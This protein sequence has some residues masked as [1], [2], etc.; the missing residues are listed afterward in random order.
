MGGWGALAIVA[1][2]ADAGVAFAQSQT[3]AGDLKGVVVDGS[4]A[5]VAGAS[6]SVVNHVTGYRR[7]ATTGPDGHYAIHALPIGL[8]RLEARLPGFETIDVP[9]VTLSL[10]APTVVDLVLQV[11]GVSYDLVVTPAR[12]LNDAAE[13]GEGLVIDRAEFDRLPVNAR[14]F[15]AFSLLT[16]TSAPDRTPQQGASR[17]S[18]LTFAGQHARSNNIVVDGMDN[19]DETVGSV[20]AVFSQEAVQQFQ[21][22]AMGY[23]A[24]F[25][26]ASGGVV[27]IVT[28]SGTNTLQGSAF[29][30]VRD[31]SLNARNHFEPSALRASRSTNRKPPTIISS[32]EQCLADHSNGT[33]CFCLARSSASTSKPATS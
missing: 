12:A 32:S 2:A 4:N 29:L 9:E 21:V 25:G 18:G 28:R 24:E 1:I 23:S 33:S 19:N 16:P 7:T 11:A 27:N 15:L 22:L 10:G 8:Y 6:V 14:N 31:D 20:R 26:K 17:T 30:Y 13:P 5:V 3:T